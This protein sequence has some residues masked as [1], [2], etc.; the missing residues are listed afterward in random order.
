MSKKV[1]EK[2]LKASKIVKENKLG[3]MPI[4]KLLLTMSLPAMFSML[5]QSLYN[6][7]DSLFVA[8]SSIDAMTALTFAFPLQQI[9]LAFALGVGVGTSTIVARRLGEKN[10]PDADK[11][12]QTGFKIAIITTLTF[13]ILGSFLPRLFMMIFTNNAKILT[14]GTNYLTICMVC[15]FGMMIE[16]LISKILQATGNMIIPMLS[17][18]LGAV[19][20]IIFDPIF[21]FVCDLGIIGAGIA[22][23]MGQIIS[24][25]FVLILAL[26]RKHIIDIMFKIKHWK[27]LKISLKGVKEIVR[28]GMPVMVMNAVAGIIVL[29]MNKIIGGYNDQAPNALGAYF[30][31]QSFVFMPVFGLNQ[32]ALP[33]MS[34]NFGAN[35]YKRYKKTFYLAIIISLT[36][37][38]IGLIVFQLCPEWLLSM[39]KNEKEMDKYAELLKVGTVTLRV[40][41]WSFLFAAVNI[42]VTTGYQSIGYGL[43]SLIMSLLRQVI[44][45]LPLA[46]V[47]GMFWGLDVLWWSYPI[48]DVLVM[49]IFTPYYLVAVKKAFAKRRNM[50][51]ASDM[52]GVLSTEIMLEESIAADIMTSD[53]QDNVR[54]EVETK[55]KIVES[56]TQKNDSCD[57][58]LNNSNNN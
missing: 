2:Q 39:F 37:M 54:V 44:F 46:I 19:I 11:L 17:Q 42:I 22:T 38:A 6:I 24:M 7:V 30:K 55:D 45:I 28:I 1:A 13:M 12:A 51:P 4:S 9:M 26:K 16:I 43:T 52:E 56:E 20:N 8:K 49:V 15:C 40:I 25:I 10:K 36:I 3:V 53:I 14:D 58:D 48:S 34:Y 35:E 32:G 21:I 57:C 27:D 31:L 50:Q 41:S 5:V 23:V 33:I 47:F 29:I 18:L